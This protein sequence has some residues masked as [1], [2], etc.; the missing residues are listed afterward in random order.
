MRTARALLLLA[1]F[2]AYLTFGLRS[3]AG[4]LVSR[5]RFDPFLPAARG[6]EHR[7]EEGR[8]QEA[9]PLALD[10][11]RAYPDEPD[12]ATS[13]ARIYHGLGDPSNEARAWEKYV[14][15]SPAP[16]EACPAL[17]QAYQQAGQSAEAQ[18]AAAR[19]AEFEA[20]DALP[21]SAPR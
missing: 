9:L 4:D 13:L 18:N 17:T 15:T 5:G 20:R 16:A 6:V 7:I 11:S 1:L 14:A 19:C 3:V 10:L 2:A 8:F 21:G 12:V